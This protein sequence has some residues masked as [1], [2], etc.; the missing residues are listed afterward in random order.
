MPRMIEVGI[1][2]D[3]VTTLKIHLT[4]KI[5]WWVKRVLL[6]ASHVSLWFVC[7]VVWSTHKPCWY[8]AAP[9]E[10]HF[11]HQKIF[12]I[13]CATI[14]N[15]T[16]SLTKRIVAHRTGNT[17]LAFFLYH[18]QFAHNHNE[19]WNLSRHNTKQ[20]DDAFYLL[21]RIFKSS[22]HQTSYE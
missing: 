11:T 14:R 13:Q 22:M 16:T 6:G 15:V 9:S 12:T 3:K 10:T 8:M 5:F 20:I 21:H 4:V 7:D 1:D 17:N 18:C 2:R 19:Y